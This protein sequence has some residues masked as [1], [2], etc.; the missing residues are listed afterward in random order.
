[1]YKA[2]TGTPVLGGQW[3]RW[4]QQSCLNTCSKF[5]TLHPAFSGGYKYFP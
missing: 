3:H 1:M 5:F 2:E 4:M